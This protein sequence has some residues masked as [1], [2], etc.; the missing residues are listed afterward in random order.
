[1][2]VTTCSTRKWFPIFFFLVAVCMSACDSYAQ[3][4][5]SGGAASLESHDLGIHRSWQ[6]G[7]SFTGGFVP[8]Y[9]IHPLGEH[10]REELDLYSV[11]F[12][13]G[14]ILTSLHGSSF[15][16]GRGESFIEI[17]PFWLANYPVQVDL[18]YRPLYPPTLAKLHELSRHGVSVTPLLFR[19]NFM[20]HESSDFVPWIQ[21]GSG[22]LWTA[23][24]FPQGRGGVGG[25]TS[26]IN[27]T[28]QAD[29]G[30]TIFTQKN[31]SMNLAVKA[32]HI[33][34]AG[35]GE[36]NPGVNMSVQFSIGY[37]WWK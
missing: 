29:F 28:P 19:W 25:N 9:E 16:R 36:Y 20:K 13:A 1:M 14:K 31:Q 34:S 27:F 17:I 23:H 26:R 2:N 24:E 11:N 32:I 35:L 4:A 12:E 21:L 15:L 6:V 5:P 3:V 10:F 30:E 18:I 22:L 33:S 8:L 7:G 37:S